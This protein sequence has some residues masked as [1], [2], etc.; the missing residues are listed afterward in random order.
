MQEMQKCSIGVLDIAILS[1]NEEKKTESIWYYDFIDYQKRDDQAVVQ[2]CIEFVISE[3]KSSIARP[4]IEIWSDTCRTQF[5]CRQTLYGVLHEV[6]KKVEVPRIRWNFFVPYHG[7]CLC[8]G[9][10]GVM[11]R[12]LRLEASRRGASESEVGISEKDLVDVL[13]G[14]GCA[15][16]TNTVVV[17]DELGRIVDD[18]RPIPEIT[19][20]LSFEAFLG[21]PSTVLI[22]TF[23]NDDVVARRHEW[24]MKA[25]PDHAEPLGEEDCDVEVDENHLEAGEMSDIVD[26]FSGI[27]SFLNDCFVMS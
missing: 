9:H 3:I 1:W 18:V 13:Q 19:K 7:K 20:Y 5:R 26:F 21:D 15:A 24:R 25:E 8:N 14:V 22:R 11:K 27:T 10:F 12:K 4:E 23:S 2:H 6:L 17:P 16:R